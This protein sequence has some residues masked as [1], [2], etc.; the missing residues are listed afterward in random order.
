MHASAKDKGRAEWFESKMK[1][2]KQ[3][4][5][6]LDK[7]TPLSG[8]IAVGGRKIFRDKCKSTIEIIRMEIIHGSVQWH[9]MFCRRHKFMS[10][11][12]RP[13]E[14]TIRPKQFSTLVSLYKSF[15]TI[16]YRT[17]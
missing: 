2:I 16:I 1:V 14:G 11:L 8:A 6:L 5:S 4:T 9:S 3:P 10:Q 15:I 17:P 12:R 7:H 13:D